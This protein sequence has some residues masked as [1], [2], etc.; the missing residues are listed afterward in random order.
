MMEAQERERARVKRADIYATN[1]QEASRYAETLRT[2]QAALVNSTQR[3]R[4]DHQDSN[5][6]YEQ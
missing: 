2:L 4:E 1:A 5:R 6:I 3:P